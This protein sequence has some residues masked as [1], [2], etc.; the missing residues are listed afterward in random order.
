MQ[1]D[2]RAEGEWFANNTA[3]YINSFYDKP[4]D[5]IATLNPHY[6]ASHCQAVSEN[7]S[8]VLVVGTTHCQWFES[9]STYSYRPAFV[10]ERRSALVRLCPK[11][12]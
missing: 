6:C 4:R 10:G 2:S 7:C 1:C 12:T 9:S 5:I 8:A 11:G 3:I